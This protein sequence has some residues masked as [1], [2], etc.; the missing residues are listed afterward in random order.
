MDD[1]HPWFR[2]FHP[3]ADAPVRL[4]C[5]PHAGGAATFY[6]P[7]SR[8]LGPAVEVLAVQY[9]GRQDRR[10]ERCVDDLRE[11]AGLIVAELRP[12]CDRPLALFGHSMG[13]T[14]AYEVARRLERD[15]TPPIGLFA[16]GRRAPSINGDESVHLRDD[17]GIV[18]ALRELSGTDSAVLVDE[19]M[20]T[21]VLPA[22][23]GDY[24]AVETYRH[25]GGPELTRPICVLVGDSDPVTS[26]AEARAWD[27]HTTAGCRV[28]VF[29]GGHFFL[30]AQAE[31]VHRA[32]LRHLGE[33]SAG[34]P[35][36]RF[37]TAQA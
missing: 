26:L 4:V 29:P 19:E 33:W 36:A 20:L 31:G 5:F 2:K 22:V 15:G 27:G 10:A 9:P 17:Q 24:R 21:M 8:A 11:L 16:S 30:R 18:Q 3:N 13:A 7:V 6:F 34:D 35:P 32:I 23:R 1:N 28:E 12:W 25:G 14:V 37:V